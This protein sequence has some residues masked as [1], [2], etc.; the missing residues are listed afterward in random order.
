MMIAAVAA[1]L[2][3][4]SCQEKET[5]YLKGYA[6]EIEYEAYQSWATSADANAIFA[7]LCAAVNYNPN[8]ANAYDRT[9]SDA[10][11]KAACKAVQEKYANV[12]SVYVLFT[13]YKITADANPDVA[14]TKEA[15]AQYAFGDALKHEYVLWSYDSN[16][17]E[18]YN[19]FKEMKDQLGEDLYKECGQS[20]LAIKQAFIDFFDTAK[21]GYTAITA[22]PWLDS[23]QNTTAVVNSCEKIYTD[24]ASRKLPVSLSYK[25]KKTA[26]LDPSKKTVVWEKTFAA[27]MD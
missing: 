23:E 15:I 7:D 5:T 9:P 12:G 17:A 22:G 25:V 13:L 1:L 14:D 16:Y 21:P 26:Y 11:K 8:G 19:A 18:A 4:V 20:Y 3:L 2:P 6:Y 27:N 24:N 10:A